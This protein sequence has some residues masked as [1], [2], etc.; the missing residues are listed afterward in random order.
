MP[1]QARHPHPAGC[2]D[3]PLNM[4]L[5]SGASHA[6]RHLSMSH[7]LPLPT[8]AGTDCQGGMG[9]LLAPYMWVARLPDRQHKSPPSSLLPAWVLLQLTIREH[10]MCHAFVGAPVLLVAFG[11]LQKGLNGRNNQHEGQSCSGAEAAKRG[12][13]VPPRQ[14]GLQQR[15]QCLPIRKLLWS[16]KPR[17]MPAAQKTSASRRQGLLSASA[18]KHKTHRACK[19]VSHCRA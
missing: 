6:P 11:I 2:L 8:K 13:R 4:Q 19:Q 5:T 12:H 18:P 14:A 9:G 15:R 3:A 10:H 7:P 16:L 1:C 17:D